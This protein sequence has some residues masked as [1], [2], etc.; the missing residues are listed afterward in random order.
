M[1]KG[2]DELKKEGYILLGAAKD[3]PHSD[4]LYNRIIG[5]HSS[6]K[7]ISPKKFQVMVDRLRNG[8][9]KF[10]NEN[11]TFKFSKDDFVNADRRLYV[12]PHAASIV[13]EYYYAKADNNDGEICI[14]RKYK[15]SHLEYIH[16][17]LNELPQEFDLAIDQVDNFNKTIDNILKYYKRDLDALEIEYNRYENLINRLENS[18]TEPYD[19]T[20]FPKLKSKKE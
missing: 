5:K 20:V 16:K 6:Q 10:F 1:K 18:N 13:E 17:K 8:K 7:S 12:S 9:D 15:R 2:I 14:N 4:T 19:P 11:S 3:N